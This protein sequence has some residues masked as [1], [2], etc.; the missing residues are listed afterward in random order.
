MRCYFC[1]VCG[2]RLVHARD[3][4]GSVS[5][6]GGCLTKLDPQMIKRAVHIWTREALVEI[7]E[8]AVRFEGEPPDD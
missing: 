2:S 7:P 8:G 3:G 6:K 1:N 4:V 5:V